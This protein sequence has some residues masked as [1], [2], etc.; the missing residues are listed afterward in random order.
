MWGIVS[1]EYLSGKKQKRRQLMII[2]DKA[3][4]SNYNMRERL[5][6][7]IYTKNCCSYWPLIELT[8]HKKKNIKT[9]EGLL[10]KNLHSLHNFKWQIIHLTQDM[11][12]KFEEDPISV[13]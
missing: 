8:M 3:K 13:Y 6:R 2:A 11:I 12:L 5:I 4:M 1:G 7:E 9:K 10:V